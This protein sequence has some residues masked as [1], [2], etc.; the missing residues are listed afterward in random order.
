MLSFDEKTLLEEYK[1]AFRNYYSN[2]TVI[3]L[4]KKLAVNLDSYLIRLEDIVPPLKF[5]FPPYRQSKYMILYVTKGAGE[6]TIGKIN[7]KIKD[8]TLMIVPPY[9]TSSSLYSD[10]I[11]GY[12]FTF[13][14]KFVLQEQFP[15]HYLLNWNLFNP[16]LV[17]YAYADVKVGNNLKGI[18]E[19]IL[20][21]ISH[22]RKHKEE[23]IALKTLELLL[24]CERLTKIKTTHEKTYQPPLLVKYIQLIQ[25][26]YKDEHSTAYYAQKLHVHPN[27]LNTAT[28]RYLQQSA[29][30]VIDEKHVNEAQVLLNQTALSV[31]EIAYELGFQSSSHFFRFFKKYTA[32]TPAAY[33]AA[34][35]KL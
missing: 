5:N 13:K 25:N 21:E 10:Y 22:N 16:S 33:R 32:K 28:K 23:L 15:R 24:V 31:K 11:K 34:H 3:D 1:K 4:D 8:R 26:H 29:K 7:V 6:K 12:D 9:I 30:S 35:L 14:L 20:D 2:K 17:P 27:S 18:F 19:S